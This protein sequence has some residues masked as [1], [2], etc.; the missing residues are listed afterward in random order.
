MIDHENSRIAVFGS[1]WRSELH[2]E[3][4]E[5]A[6]RARWPTTEIQVAHAGH[7]R[8][9][10]GQ[11]PQQQRVQQDARSPVVRALTTTGSIGTSAAA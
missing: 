5:D 4:G 6:R 11:R 10:H 7:R 3:P 1:A 8:E 2:G 9:E